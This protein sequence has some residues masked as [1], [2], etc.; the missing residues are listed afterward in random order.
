MLQ[1][2]ADTVSYVTPIAGPLA[3]VGVALLLLGLTGFVVW[4]F[5]CW[6]TGL[7]RYCGRSLV[8][9]GALFLMFEAAWLLFGVE[10]SVKNA[11][12]APFWVLGLGFVFPGVFMR[13]V[14]AIRP[15]H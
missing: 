6:G 13:L 9:I 4:V 5:C 3:Y 8:V 12:G 10:P 11:A 1:T 15:T 2:I 7:M 14:G